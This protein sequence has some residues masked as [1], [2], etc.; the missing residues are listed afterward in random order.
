MHC[1]LTFKCNLDIYMSRVLYVR[2]GSPISRRDARTRIGTL[3]VKYYR[4][5]R[6]RAGVVLFALGDGVRD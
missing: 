6:P 5:V 2:V 3:V 4:V 1:I